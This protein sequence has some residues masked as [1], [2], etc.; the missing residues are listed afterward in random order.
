MGER[1]YLPFA[2]TPNEHSIGYHA[3]AG[4]PS[5]QHPPVQNRAAPPVQNRIDPSQRHALTHYGGHGYGNDPLSAR[6]IAR[7][8]E[9]KAGDAPKLLSLW[10]NLRQGRPFPLLTDLNLALLENSQPG[11]FL[12]KRPSRGEAP[13]LVCLGKNFQDIARSI[14]GPSAEIPPR[15]ALTFRQAFSESMGYTLLDLA[16]SVAAIHH[17]LARSGRDVF[18]GGRLVVYRMVLMPVSL[19]GQGVSHILGDLDHRFPNH[20]SGSHR[21]P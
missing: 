7:F 8:F 12:L 20:L 2:E 18:P 14:A 4:R 21:A 17:P 13:S 9:G 10:K 19:D 16:E 15:E 11:H 6:E 1:N 3:E 5:F